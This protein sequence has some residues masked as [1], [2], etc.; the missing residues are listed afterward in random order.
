LTEY[1]N[2]IAYFQND[3]CTVYITCDNLFQLWFCCSSGQ[4]R[5]WSRLFL[6]NKIRKADNCK[7]PVWATNTDSSYTQSYV[8]SNSRHVY[9]KPHKPVFISLLNYKHCI[10]MSEKREYA[11]VAYLEL[12]RI[13]A[14]SSKVRT[15]HIFSAYF[16][17]S[18]ALNILCSN[19][20]DLRIINIRC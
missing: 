19:F 14:Y 5:R 1:C 6:T 16:G 2:F 11:I 13:F 12:C 4:L 9:S 10:G 15:P 20:S 3:P 17:I 18:A 7:I 8:A